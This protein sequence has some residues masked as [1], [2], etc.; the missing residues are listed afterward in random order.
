VIGRQMEKNGGSKMRLRK[1][2]GEK[3]ICKN[4]L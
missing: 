2:D 1:E 4:K 3:K